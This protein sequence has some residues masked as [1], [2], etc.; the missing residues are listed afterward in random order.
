MKVKIENYQ[1]IKEAEFEVKG[2]TV[3]SGAN[4]TGKSACAR[5]LTGVFSNT[6]GHSHVRIGEKFSSVLV[7]F[8]DSKTIEWRKGKGVNNYLV[9]GELIDKVGSSVPDEVKASGVVSVDVS[10]KEVWPQVAKQFEQI[11]LLDMPPS[12]LSS[13]L[14]DVEKIQA[15]EKASDLANSD[16]RKA[17]TRLKVKNEDLLLEKEKEANFEGISDL[18]S[19]LEEKNLLEEEAETFLSQADSLSR[20]RDARNQYLRSIQILEDLGDVELP[21]VDL[22][23]QESLKELTALNIERNKHFMTTMSIGVGLESFPDLPESIPDTSSLESV[24]S[25][26]KDLLGAISEI[27]PV[28]SLELP[29]IKVDDSLDITKERKALASSISTLEDNLATI[30]AD[31]EGLL[32]SM[33]EICPLCERGLDH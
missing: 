30:V 6:R 16:T 22:S 29:T 32:S 23:L 31:L 27:E 9:D 13:A 15:L 4:N 24:Q 33:G 18:E 17:K 10:G 11:F 14:S 19:I 20:V 21:N 3:I 26:R 28:L 25:K 5:A 12:V 1:S 7:D 8:G 2:L